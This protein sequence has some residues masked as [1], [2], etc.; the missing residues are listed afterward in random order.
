MRMNSWK[1]V[2]HDIAGVIQE[3]VKLDFVVAEPR[4]QCR[5]EHVGLRRDQRLVR[6]AMDVLEF[7]CLGLEEVAQRRAIGAGRLPPIF[8]DRVPAFAQ[9]FN[10]GVTVLRDERGDP[11]WMRES[12]AE[13]R[14][15]LP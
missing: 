8:L 14:L 10:V 15:I 2:K 7:G 6:D 5:V 13:A 11:L 12:E 1:L 4:D 3:Q 9:T